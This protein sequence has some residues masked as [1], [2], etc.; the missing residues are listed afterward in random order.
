MNGGGLLKFIRI[1]LEVY[2]KGLL[3]YSRVGEVGDVY[4]GRKNIMCKGIEMLKVK[5]YLEKGF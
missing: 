5:L 2:F 4:L 1:L 3:K